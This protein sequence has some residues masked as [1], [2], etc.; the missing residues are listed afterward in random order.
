TGVG[1]S[2]DYTIEIDPDKA[3]D[4]TILKIGQEQIAPDQEIVKV[5]VNDV[6]P[7]IGTAWD[8]IAVNFARLKVRTQD[9]R[10]V[11]LIG[12]KPL[13]GP[14]Q[15]ANGFTLPATDYQ[16]FLDLNNLADA[17]NHNQRIKLQEKQKLELW[18]EADDFC[19]PPPN[20]GSSRHLWIELT[21]PLSK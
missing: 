8:D 19:E 2:P 21:P 11:N 18:V 5:P 20:V 12:G 3:P 9:G 1:R 7:V 16:L 17:K 6:V 15:Q 13:E 14:L 10:E 4:V